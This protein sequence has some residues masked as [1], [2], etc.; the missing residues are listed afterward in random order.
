MFRIL[1][2]GYLCLEVASV[3]KGAHRTLSLLSKNYWSVWCSL[4][5]NSCSCT[6]RNDVLDAHIEKKFGL[7]PKM[8][9]EPFHEKFIQFLLPNGYLHRGRD[10][11]ARIYNSKDKQ[12]WVNNKQHRDNDLPAMIWED[13]TKLWFVNGKRHRANDLPATIWKHPI[14]SSEEWFFNGKRHREGGLSK[15]A[16]IWE[17][18]MKQWWIW[19]KR[20]K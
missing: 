4:D 5:E 14:S 2:D 9:E 13:G 19:G 10:L 11:P 12:W 8:E 15:P 3:V 1:R 6:L 17:S 18:G 7:L 16:I 20:V